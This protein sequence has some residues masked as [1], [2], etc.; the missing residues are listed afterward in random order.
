MNRYLIYYSDGTTAYIYAM[1]ET[2]AKWSAERM[3]PYRVVKR[4]EYKPEGC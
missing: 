1:N 4:I 3:T 2:D